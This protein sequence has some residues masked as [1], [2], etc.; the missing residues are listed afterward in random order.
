MQET[1]YAQLRKFGKAVRTARHTLG[2]SQEAFAEKCGL[3]VTHIGKIERAEQNVSF[4]T[5]TRI[6]R[7]LRMRLSDFFERAKL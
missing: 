4:E 6:C 1:T 7:A 5:I 2:M 3:A